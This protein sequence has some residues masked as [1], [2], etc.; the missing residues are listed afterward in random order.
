MTMLAVALRS[1]ATKNLRGIWRFSADKFGRSTAVAY[2]NAILDKIDEAR[3]NPSIGKPYN[4][5]PGVFRLV[6][7]RHVVFYRVQG[8]QIIVIRILHERMNFDQH[9]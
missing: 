5:R 9:L 2:Y 8:V 3:K 1:E 4:S 6:S 7:G